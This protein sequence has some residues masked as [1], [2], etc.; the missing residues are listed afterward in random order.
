MDTPTNCFFHPDI[1]ACDKCSVCGKNICHM[2]REE[3]DK[4]V[5]CKE[6]YEKMFP[7]PKIEENPPLEEKK[8]ATSGSTD[9]KK[10]K[11]NDLAI[12]SFALSVASIYFH[13]LSAIPAIITGIIA[14]KQLKENNQNQKG[15]EFA[16]AGIIIGSIF[17]ALW[18]FVLCFYGTIYGSMF[19]T[20]CATMLTNG[21][22]N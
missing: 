11:Y 5:Y 22:A 16:L 13:L 19:F 9:V 12:V 8:T 6:C 15:D 3:V 4:K 1:I 20:L 10:V 21:N 14:R 18:S 17:F 7:A 2:C